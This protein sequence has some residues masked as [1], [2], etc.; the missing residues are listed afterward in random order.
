MMPN[1]IQGWV[2]LIA[3]VAAALISVIAAIKGGQARA[4]AKATREAMVPGILPGALPAGM[5]I[6]DLFRYATLIREVLTVVK[7]IGR[8]SP[9]QSVQVPRVVLD[10]PGGE[11]INLAP[12]TATRDR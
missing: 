5:D 7:N 3:A 10:L 9:G 1:Q 6:T 12:T 11:R 4:E 8:M 2:T